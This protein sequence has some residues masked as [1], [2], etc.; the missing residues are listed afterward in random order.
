VLWYFYVLF[1]YRSIVSDLS[2]RLLLCMLRRGVIQ[3]HGLGDYR[4]NVDHLE[5]GDGTFAPGQPPQ[6]TST[7]RTLSTTAGPGTVFFTAGDGITPPMVTVNL[8][9]DDSNGGGGASASGQGGAGAIGPGA[10]AVQA[11]DDNKDSGIGSE[12]PTHAGMAS[13]FSQAVG[14]AGKEAIKLTSS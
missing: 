2:H 14:K 1:Q 3:R 4:L 5:R 9:D 10:S 13:R 11:G 12:T 8:N 7:P 6:S